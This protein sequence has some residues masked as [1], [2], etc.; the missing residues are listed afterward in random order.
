MKANV[1]R[2]TCIGCGVCEEK[3]PGVFKIDCDNI[4]IVKVE[5]IPNDLEVSAINARDDC[6]VDAITIV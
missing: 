5:E 6:P 4:A 2:D 3:S 1:N